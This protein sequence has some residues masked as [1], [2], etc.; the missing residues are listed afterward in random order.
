MRGPFYWTRTENPSGF[1]E[2]NGSY[3]GWDGKSGM[4]QTWR[5]EPLD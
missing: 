2:R 1:E 5:K 4:G 3:S